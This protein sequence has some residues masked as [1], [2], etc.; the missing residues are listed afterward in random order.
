MVIYYLTFQYRVPERVNISE[1]IKPRT[2]IFQARACDPD[3][4]E[5]AVI[6]EFYTP[7]G[8]PICK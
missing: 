3:I 2:F 8:D 1:G 7:A 5:N 4:I 6:Y